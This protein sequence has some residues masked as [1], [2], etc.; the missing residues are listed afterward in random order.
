MRTVLLSERQEGQK[1]K[2]SLSYIASH[3]R[4][5]LQ[6]ETETKTEAKPE[7]LGGL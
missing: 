1:F 6:T 2:A 5:C 3:I 7:S 4:S